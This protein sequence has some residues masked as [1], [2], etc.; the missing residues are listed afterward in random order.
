MILG[1]CFFQFCNPFNQL[2]SPTTVQTDQFPSESIFQCI[3]ATKPVCCWL[4]PLG[5]HWIRALMVF[6][7][8]FCWCFCWC[9]FVGWL[10]SFFV[11]GGDFLA[12]LFWWILFG[13]FYFL[14]LSFFFAKVAFCSP[15]LAIPKP[16]CAFALTRLSPVYS[17]SPRDCPEYPSF[18]FQS[19]VTLS[20][21][22]C[23]SSI[24]KL[25]LPN[26]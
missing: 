17:K 20:S 11:R 3:F 16:S 6:C 15:Q 8:F 7:G 23:K 2:T 26:H 22:D 21:L 9:F 10:G 18:T 25:V 12:G 24:S 1:Q 14:K 4:F 5:P 13:F 19:L